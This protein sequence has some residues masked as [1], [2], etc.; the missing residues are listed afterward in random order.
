M[1][2]NNMTV[3]LKVRSAN[4]IIALLVIIIALHSI[5]VK[6]TWIRYIA[7]TIREYE[8]LKHQVPPDKLIYN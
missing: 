2:F 4:T 8:N 5:I 6:V 7:L 1:F 3:V